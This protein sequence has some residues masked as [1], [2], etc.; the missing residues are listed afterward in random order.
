MEDLLS[1]AEQEFRRGWTTV[2]QWQRWFLRS[3]IWDFWGKGLMALILANLSKA[4]SLQWHRGSQ[5]LLCC[6]THNILENKLEKKWY[7]PMWSIGNSSL[8]PREQEEN[9][10]CKLEKFTA[11]ACETWCTAGL[12]FQPLTFSLN[13][14]VKFLE[15]LGKMLVFVDDITI[16]SSGNTPEL[17]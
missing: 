3:W 11:V 5:N 16:Y 15:L 8:I 13:D 2:T 10:I 6:V 12:S 9:F 1:E 17:A 7:R 14:C 4:M